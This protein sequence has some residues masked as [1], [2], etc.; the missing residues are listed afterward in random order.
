MPELGGDQEV[1]E[2]TNNNP[3]QGGGASIALI[4][5]GGEQNVRGPLQ[6]GMTYFAGVKRKEDQRAL[7]QK[8]S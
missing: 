4:C 2:G 3:Y 8:L 5:K 6:G 1:S 7:P